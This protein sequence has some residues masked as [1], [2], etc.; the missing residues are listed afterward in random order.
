M[1]AIPAWV[2]RFGLVTRALIV[3]L[4]FGIFVGLLAL[5]SS[6]LVASALAATVL[7][8]LIYGWFM[9]RRMS[10]Y[11]P[12]AKD[13]SGPDRVA[14]ARATRSGDDIHDPHLASGV[15]DY[16]RGLHLAA[17][18]F[19]LWWWLIVLLGLVALGTAVADTIFGP[20]SEAMVSWLYFAFFPFEVWWWPRRQAKLLANAERA[21]K[22]AR[23]TLAEQT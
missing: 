20:V 8:T 23:R 21:E 6:N 5:I 18:G 4:A 13:F 1:V 17:E 11:W 3:G 16:S 12:G 7:V 22:S 2:W 9:G 15:I 10:K 19:R 14:V